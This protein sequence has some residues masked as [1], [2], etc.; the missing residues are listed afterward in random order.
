MNYEQI[1]FEVESGVAV[2]TLNRPEA[3]N[4]WTALMASELSDAMH[5]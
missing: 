5:R 2:V 1:L 3:M 4:T